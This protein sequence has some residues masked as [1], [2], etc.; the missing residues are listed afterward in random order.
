MKSQLPIIIAMIILTGLVLTSL[1]YSTIVTT[2]INDVN[3]GSTKINWDL[4]D[5]ELDTLD[6]V[7][8][9]YASRYAYYN[10]SNT[11]LSQYLNPIYKL[12]LS[13]RN[14]LY[15]SD[16]ITDPS[17][18]FIFWSGNWWWDSTHNILI[19]KKTNSFDYAIALIDTDLKDIFKSNSTVYLAFIGKGDKHI[20]YVIY[21]HVFWPYIYFHRDIYLSGYNLLT[22]KLEI[23]LYWYDWFLGFERSGIE[24][25]N[26]T[27]IDTVPYLYIG[28]YSYEYLDHKYENKINLTVYDRNLSMYNIQ[29][30]FYDSSTLPDSFDV[31]YF[32]VGGYDNIE[33]DKIVLS[34]AVD[35]RYIYV[36]NVPPGW[37]IIITNG[38]A[39]YEGISDEQGCVKILFPDLIWR[40]A[41]I[42]VYTQDDRKVFEGS[43]DVIVGGDEY[44]LELIVQI[45]S[46]ENYDYYE[47]LQNF[48]ISIRDASN[49]AL[50][51]F[52]EN[53]LKVINN[54]IHYK[55]EE[56][57]VV[58]VSYFKPFYNVSFWV[59]NNYVSH[60][61][62]SIGFYIKY[63]IMSPSGEYMEFT[64]SINATYLLS[65]DSGYPY[66]FENMTLPINLTAV[67]QINNK[68]FYYMLSV[69]ELRLK[70]YSIIFHELEVFKPSSKGTYTISLVPERV[71]YLQ[72]GIMR[73]YYKIRY[74]KSTTKI[75]TIELYHDV[76]NK[77]YPVFGYKYSFLWATTAKADIDGV[78][79]PAAL[80]IVFIYLYDPWENELRVRIYGDEN[81]PITPIT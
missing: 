21:G 7:A 17:E 14:A 76:V 1:F 81:R 6:L 79:V 65:F 10:F 24:Y 16:F 50:N 8:L 39:S 70:I 78:I 20:D 28:S 41:K 26:S 22:S 4:I 12:K 31:F 44:E 66:G 80:K 56:G 75:A 69:K 55:S 43:F 11:F 5:N 73:S 60:G 3:R 77:L 40:N 19:G 58:K 36:S 68:T 59:D 51:V 74:G 35:P 13:K 33:I 54:W 49:C 42:L 29:Y 2:Y 46:L 27:R 9:K 18:D 72:H 64:K 32:G 48:S 45:P 67:L 71:L 38:T 15:Y 30:T 37:R 61:K 53:V 23:I 25:L 62:G 52:K 63:C 34:A 57:Y 47:D